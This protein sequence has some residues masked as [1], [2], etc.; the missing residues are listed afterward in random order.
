MRR[1]LTIKGTASSRAH[2]RVDVDVVGI[3][4]D[5]VGEDGLARL[6]DLADDAFAHLDLEPLGL[7]GVADLEAHTQ[8]VGAVVEQQNRKDAVV[9][10]GADQ[11]GGP[12]Q[13]R[14][15]IESG[16]ESV[17]ETEQKLTLQRLDANLRRRCSNIGARPVVALESVLPCWRGGG[18]GGRDLGVG[19]FF[20]HKVL[21]FPRRRICRGCS[22]FVIISRR[23]IV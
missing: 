20:G 23:R 8:I 12:V 7:G 9:D 5:V 14:L 6:R 1:F 18:L 22:R 16:I 17:G 13:E 2:G 21:V 4:E 19:N 3:L 11:S 15:E 10:D